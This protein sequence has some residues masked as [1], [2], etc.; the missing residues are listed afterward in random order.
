MT[1]LLCH[2]LNLLL[3]ASWFALGVGRTLETIQRKQMKWWT[4]LLA[5]QWLAC[6][7]T[8]VVGYLEAFWRC[9]GSS[10]TIRHDLEAAF[11]F[12]SQ[13]VCLWFRNSNYS[14]CFTHISRLNLFHTHHILFWLNL[15]IQIH[16]IIS[17]YFVIRFLCVLHLLKAQ[18]YW[19]YT[20]SRH[21]FV[22]IVFCASFSTISHLFHL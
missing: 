7:F 19:Y 18:V 10:S 8:I 15:V 21:S 2:V 17:I 4:S 9:V 14:C 6:C 5:V 1:N 13:V 12:T 3:K 22:L 16:N 20:C 11:K